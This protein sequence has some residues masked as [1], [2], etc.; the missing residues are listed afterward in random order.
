MKCFEC[1][2]E[3]AEDETFYCPRCGATVCNNCNDINENVCPYCNRSN[4]Y[5][6]N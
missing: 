3:I 5:L 4:L 2:K 1:G 6:Y